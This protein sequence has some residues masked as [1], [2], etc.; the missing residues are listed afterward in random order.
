MFRRFGILKPFRG[1][2]GGKS[3]RFREYLNEYLSNITSQRQQPRR[4]INLPKPLRN[5]PPHYF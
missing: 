3:L 1:C 2:R 4:Q 5:S